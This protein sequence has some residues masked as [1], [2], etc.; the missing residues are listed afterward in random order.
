MYIQIII[1]GV[2]MVFIQS[3]LTWWGKRVDEVDDEK[4]N[5]ESDEEEKLETINAASDL[6][7][8]DPIESMEISGFSVP[9]SNDKNGQLATVLIPV[10]DSLRKLLREHHMELRC[11]PVDLCS[12]TDSKGW[13]CKRSREEGFRYCAK[14]RKSSNDSTKRRWA[15]HVVYDSKRSDTKRRYCIDDEDYIT[16]DW[17]LKQR[18]RQ[19]NL[20]YYCDQEMQIERRTAYNGLQAERLTE[21]LAHLK[22]ICVLACGNCNRRSHY[23]RFCP[24]P[25]GKARELGYELDEFHFFKGIPPS[26][27]PSRLSIYQEIQRELAEQTQPQ[28]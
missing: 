19:N 6:V 5:A 27:L 22:G 1:A 25:I 12:N 8:K 17:V 14:C 7:T 24:Y 2:T 26:C 23:S 20:C 9:P 28:E 10:M 15:N 11:I 16:A 13:R 4:S 3:V 21:A 18:E